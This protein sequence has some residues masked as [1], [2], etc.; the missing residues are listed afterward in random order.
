MTKLIGLIIN[1][2]LIIF[3]RFSV[4]FFDKQQGIA[5]LDEIQL[6]AW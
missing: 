5:G 4:F 6:L 3:C 2:Y 1:D